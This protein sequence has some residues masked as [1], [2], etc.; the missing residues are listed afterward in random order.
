MGLNDPI[1]QFSYFVSTMKARHP[2]MAYLHL[3]EPQISG[4]TDRV[5]AAHESNDFL[6]AIWGPAPLIV[7]GGHTRE[8][9]IKTTE[10]H[11]GE[12]VAFGRYYISNVGNPL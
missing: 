11:E 12:L 10:A 6:R 9:A 2:N 8:S 5:A 1:P 7:G 3:V 4:N